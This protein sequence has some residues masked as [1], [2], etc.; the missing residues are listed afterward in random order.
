MKKLIRRLAMTGLC[1]A[2]SLAVMVVPASAKDYVKENLERK[3]GYA[4]DYFGLPLG[5]QVDNHKVNVTSVSG[6]DALF[7]IQAHTTQS[8]GKKGDKVFF[9][10]YY[11]GM[12]GKLYYTEKMRFDDE[13]RNFLDCDKALQAGQ[14]NMISVSLYGGAK[15][16]LGVYFYKNGGKG[17]LT[18]D[19]LTVARVSGSIGPANGDVSGYKFREFSGRYEALVTGMT[20]L[21]N[22]NTNTGEIW[23]TT[24]VS[25]STPTNHSIY[26]LELVAGSDGYV[27]KNGTVT[28]N[29]TNVL[30]CA[31][32][33][34]IRF[35][36]GY[37]AVQPAKNLN[38]IDKNGAFKDYNHTITS[39]WFQTSVGEMQGLAAGYVGNYYVYQ[40]V[41]ETC[42]RPYTGTTFLLTMPQYITVNSISV[43]LDEDDSL[44]LQSVRLV[45]L[46]YVAQ[47]Y[48]NYWNG[49]FGLERTRPWTGRLLAQSVGNEY[50]IEGKHSVTF[51]RRQTYDYLRLQTYTRGKGPE[52]DNTGTGVGVSI[53]LADVLGA[54]IETFAAWNGKSYSD[55][56]ARFAA[57]EQLKNRAGD[58]ARKA[59]FN[60]NC[61]KQECMN[62]TIDYKDTLGA[63]RRVQVPLS[64]AYL[65]YILKENQGKLTG[66]DWKTWISG[67][68]QQNENVALPMRL[69]EYDEIESISLTYGAAPEGFTSSNSGRVDAGNDPLTIENICFYEEV[70]GS[71]FTS[72]YDAEKLSCVLST[73]LKPAYSY[74]VKG[75]Q[76]LTAGGTV[77]ASVSD[78]S[79]LKEAPA[80]RDYSNRYIVKIKTADIETAGSKSPIY[81]R[82]DYT[83]VNGD[84]Q[85]TAEY[86]LTTQAAN[87][88]GV[89]YRYKLSDSVATTLQYER[90]IRR[91]CVCECM[92]EIPNVAS[93]DDI[94]LNIQGA[95]EWQVEYVNIFHVSSLEQRWGERKEQEDDNSASHLYWRRKYTGDKVAEARQ[96]VLLYPNNPSKT[97]YFTTYD[98][99][100]TAIKPEQNV[101][102]DEY[103]TSLPSSMTFNEAKKNL[104]LSVVKYT[105]QV[106][107]KVADV[108]DAG[109]SNYFYFQL[110]FENGTSAVVLANQQLASDS[111]RRAMTESFQIKTTQNYGEIKAVRIICDN[112]SSTSNVFDKLNIEEIAVTLGSDSGVSKSWMVKNVG[113][114]DIAYVDEGSDASVENLEQL[115]EKEDNS[116]SNAEIVKEFAVN[117]RATAVDLLFCI[118]TDK[119]SANDSS[120]PYKNA[121]GGT[122]E[123]T[124]IYRDSNGVE[125]QMNFDL[126]AQI[127]QYNDTENTR[128]MYRPNHNDRFVL[129]MTD[130]KSAQALHITRTDGKNNWVISNVSIQQVG[131]M[132]P[133]YLSEQLT[134]SEYYRDFTTQEDVA[135]SANAAGVT[136]RISGSGNAAIAFTN[137]SIDLTTPQEQ[138]SWSSVITREPTTTNET[139]NIYLFPGSVVGLKRGF[140]SS[141]PAVRATAKYTTIYGGSLAQKAFTIGHLGNIGGE[142]V[143]FEKNLDIS[144]VATLNSLRLSTTTSSGEQPYIN[145]AVV[146]RVRDGVVMGTYYFNYA[147]VYL[148]NGPQE[149]AASSTMRGEA[150]T[151][152]V[153]LQPSAG[154]NVP[155]TAETSDVA[156]A[157]RYTSALDAS[158]EKT[159]YRSPYVYLT[160]A[161]Y[162]SMTT[163]QL[164]EVPFQVENVGEVVGINIVSTGPIAVFDNAVIYNYA[165]GEAGTGTP[166]SVTA[167]AEQFAASSI[168]TSLEG[169]GEMVTPALFRFVTAPEEASTGAGTTGKASMTVKYM[170]S[171]GLSRTMTVDDLFSY[172]NTSGEETGGVIRPGS[173]TEIALQLS[174]AAY[175][176]SIT[177]TAADR[178][179]IA[180][181]YAELKA[182]GESPSVSS[183]TV[184]NWASDAA[185]LTIDLLPATEGGEGTGNQIQTFTV[186]GR[187]Q[188][189][190]VTA[191][192]SAG[193][194]LLVTAYPG[195]TVDLLP[196]VTAVGK[197]DTTWSW[198][199]GDYAGAL[200][201]NQDQSASFRVPGKLAPGDSC[202][203]S[204]SCNGDNR[205]SVAVTIVVEEEK[206]EEPPASTAFGG[207]GG[208][209]SPSTEGPAGTV[210]SPENETITEV[211]NETN[212]EP[213]NEPADEPA[214]EPADEPTDEPADEP[215]EDSADEPAG[216]SASEV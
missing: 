111:F 120:N 211:G 53:Q 179:L 46:S 160:D 39:P 158:A 215:S 175:L 181:V 191:S 126:S 161:G 209:G 54:G 35:R 195:D 156:V 11:E 147:N 189:T 45:E 216:E 26:A 23:Y 198:N 56:E 146:E 148:G 183:T 135:R 162:Q 132:G 100:G 25:A 9:S 18:M 133:V 40:D 125:Q 174:N 194:T 60:L 22:D 37:G 105:Y 5:G 119:D 8:Y 90:H 32:S 138:E 122:M 47:D 74:S 178:W 71:N 36:E 192:A 205:M 199:V 86:S 94:Y 41:S 145:Y 213:V 20:A 142:T 4:I 193:G 44:S 168:P 88:F 19:W 200:S 201:V 63:H 167:L 207:G 82:L 34:S 118:T 50:T 95:D 166:R 1:A 6:N 52:V 184:N 154:Q 75:G 15:R 81:F 84:K 188:K 55:K 14:V 117:S 141:T 107:V 2:M 80:A 12:D 129:S 197:P 30:G 165:G 68:F 152:T 99:Q 110:V 89:N 48:E 157:L 143:L 83:D 150:M 151:Q 104:G 182:P 13:V 49:A 24:P 92:V 85:S 58:D 113:W 16:V 153:R 176:D 124:L 97:I 78:G 169:N 136:Y 171:R 115:N 109:S 116:L 185:P 21:G 210:D 57:W 3:A 64:T 128:W 139:M 208:G 77:S 130:I 27:N 33:Q 102:S 177:L 204:V 173:T 79:L 96:S 76:Q 203:F 73:S 131:G 70:T 149:C 121:L 159:V 67:V 163:G 72:K 10:L 93:I 206:R 43:S 65:V 28:V 101:K 134:G 31:Y 155:L 42:L 87:F 170:D 180:S 186:T 108:E 91:G 112:T 98:E 140:D 7:V 103:L 29:Y 38:D 164:L 144:A 69:A 137:N 202:T 106:N 127:Q 212:G 190:G 51:S 59:W 172:Q 66:G 187:G 17:P 114:I 62:L 214:E 123:A 61:F 196:A